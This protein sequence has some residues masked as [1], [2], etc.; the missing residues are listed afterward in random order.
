MSDLHDRVAA[1]IADDPDP[2]TRDELTGLLRASIAGDAT[3]HTELSDRFSGLLRF[4]TAG[5]RGALGGGP[6]RM[7]LAVVIRAAAGIAAWI[8]DEAADR[9]E[10]ARIVIGFD[11]RHRS[12]DFA[13]ES[14]R[15]LAAAGIRARLLPEPTPTPVL[16]FAVRHLDA[17]AGIMVTASH[18]PPGDNGYKVY[19]RS[20]AQIV[21]PVDR[22]IAEVLEAIGSVAEVER[23][24][25]TDPLIDDLDH[26]VVDRYVEA[27]AATI[28]PDGARGLS[29]AYTPLHGVGA[30]VFRRV[31]EAAGFARPVEVREQIDPDPD[32][33]TV[34]FPNPEE[35]GALDLGL[36]T[37]AA[38]GA[39]LL[40]AS[41]PD[42]DRLGA[43]VPDPRLGEPDSPAGWRVLRGDEIGIILADRILRRPR[44]SDRP[45]LTATTIVSS[46][47]LGR[48]ADE[49]GVRFRETLTGFKWLSRAP[50]DDEELVFAYEEALGFAVAPHLVADK[51]GITAALL[52]AEIAS[53]EKAR[54]RTVLDVLDDLERRHGVHRTAQWSTRVDGA[55]GM[56]RL[57]AAMAG[58]RGDPPSGLGGEEI[59][60]VTDLAGGLRDLPPSDV[61]VFDLDGARIVVRPSGTEPKLKCYLEVREGVTDAP[62]D[63][64]AARNRASE[65]IADLTS[66]IAVATGLG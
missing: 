28:A 50:R 49:T 12:A 31:F 58:L 35:P 38:A 21:A 44:D 8:R 56:E 18:N 43:A 34:E 60:A 45:A 29:I 14:A 22:R 62:G 51:D 26:D 53:T 23:A 20:G 36:A 7:N 40:I 39:D 48:I 1:W 32:F 33:P 16:A 54:D 10:P 65:R 15:V 57:I 63:L 59:V 47:F 2:I 30:G 6:S 42:A 25:P 4:G 13:R 46:S 64:L 27:A 41:D 17:A 11:A 66:A 5:L 61:L 55:D 3:A 19:D 52:L 24:D 37:A 9:S